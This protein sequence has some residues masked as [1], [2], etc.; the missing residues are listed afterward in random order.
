MKNININQVI[1]FIQDNFNELIEK[2]K[3]TFHKEYKA[4]WEND[5]GIFYITHD[6]FL[7]YIP[8]SPIES[9]KLELKP[10]L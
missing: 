7:I 10:K 9:I 1:K 2:H 8:S 5:A 3:L 4:G 6:D